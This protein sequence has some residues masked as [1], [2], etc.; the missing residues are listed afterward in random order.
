MICRRS[1]LVCPHQ[2]VDIITYMV[3][4]DGLPWFREFSERL[5]S[6]PPVGIR[7]MF[8]ASS[9][10]K[11][12]IAHSNARKKDLSVDR[13]LAYHIAYLDNVTARLQRQVYTLVV[14]FHLD[15]SNPY[16]KHIINLQHITVG[17]CDMQHP[18]LVTVT[19]ICWKSLSIISIFA[20][21]LIRCGKTAIKLSTNKKVSKILLIYV[22]VFKYSFLQN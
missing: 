1:I 14:A 6:H 3:R 7:L 11:T 4:I 20:A 2:A 22:Y 16:A 21:A 18:A 13:N 19:V 10:G 12:A 8:L 5:N 9:K 17:S 15:R